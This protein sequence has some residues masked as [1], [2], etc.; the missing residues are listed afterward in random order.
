[1]PFE[2]EEREREEVNNNKVFNSVVVGI[3][4]RIRN[5]IYGC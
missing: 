5:V 4:K 2:E 3:F 1:M